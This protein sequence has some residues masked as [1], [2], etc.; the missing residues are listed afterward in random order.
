MSCGYSF[1]HLVEHYS[2]SSMT[3]V[4][5][6]YPDATFGA[7]MIQGATIAA[8]EFHFHVAVGTKTQGI[9]FSQTYTSLLPI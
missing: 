7:F 4:S 5:E 2:L 6:E 9:H 8:V 1:S 3:R